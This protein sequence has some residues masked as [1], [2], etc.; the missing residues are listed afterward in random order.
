MPFRTA[1][2]LLMLVAGS[3]C[4]VLLPWSSGR[5]DRAALQNRRPPEAWRGELGRGDRVEVGLVDGTTTHARWLGVPVRDTLW[6]EVDYVR[7]PLRAADV[8]WVRRT[9]R[10]HVGSA[11]FVGGL[12]DTGIGLM[13]LMAFLAYAGSSSG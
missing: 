2:L 13:A 5:A 7:T 9:P 8:A 12:I 4:T 11:F 10:S 6:S 3:G 1:L